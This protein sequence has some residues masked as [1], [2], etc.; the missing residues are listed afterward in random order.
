M[1][2]VKESPN[3]THTDI[4]GGRPQIGLNLPRSTNTS[5]TISSFDGK[6]I[7]NS[8]YT[9]QE[10]NN[11]YNDTSHAKRSHHRS[12]SERKTLAGYRSKTAHAGTVGMVSISRYA[13]HCRSACGDHR[14]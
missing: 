4:F 14:R 5:P 6:A 9:L 10:K 11:H 1:A 3:A 8:A 2:D 13:N 7:V 12:L